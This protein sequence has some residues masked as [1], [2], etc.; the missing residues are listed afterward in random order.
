MEEKKIEMVWGREVYPP[1]RGAGFIFP[2]DLK[3]VGCGLCQEACSMQHHG[4]INKDY[5]KIFIRKVLL[6]ISKAVIVTCSQCQQEERE[7]QKACP[8]SP[9]AIYFDDKTQHMLVDKDRCTA[10]LA[11]QAA[12]GTEAIRTNGDLGETPFVCDLCDVNNTGQRDPQCVKACPASA[13][14]FQNK[15]DRGRPQREYFRKSSS[16]K[17]ALIAKR[18]Y[19]LTPDSVTYPPL[20]P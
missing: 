8:V 19:P 3:C 9:P 1:P 13:L 18:L 16:E 4:V 10:C 5:A 11:C 15:E 14:Q 12:C 7:C 2:D 17:A 20:K 6:P